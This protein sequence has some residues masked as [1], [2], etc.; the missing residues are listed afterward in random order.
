[1]NSSISVYFP[2]PRREAEH[3]LDAL[4]LVEPV[5]DNLKLHGVVSFHQSCGAA[6]ANKLLDQ[7]PIA[8]KSPLAIA[9]NFL[10]VLG[11]EY[12]HRD[13]V[14][15]ID[16]QCFLDIVVLIAIQISR[17]EHG[18]CFSKSLEDRALGGTISTPGAR[19]H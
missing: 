1:M 18:G 13:A 14:S 6:F 19:E 17:D 8:G 7:L 3:P 10:T 12:S 16:P 15:A 9:G 11:K 5:L 4:E 2:Q